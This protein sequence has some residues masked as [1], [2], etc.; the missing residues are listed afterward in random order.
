MRERTV[1]RITLTRQTL[2][3]SLLVVGV[4]FLVYER[5][6]EKEISHTK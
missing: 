5:G 4:L 3:K 6:G 1:R 2:I